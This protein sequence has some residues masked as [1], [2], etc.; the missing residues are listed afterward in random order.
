MNDLADCGTKL[1]HTVPL[2]ADLRYSRALIGPPHSA[3]CSAAPQ[4][5]CRAAARA[6]QSPACWSVQVPA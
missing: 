4:T 2:L 3:W 1:S 5:L 6:Q